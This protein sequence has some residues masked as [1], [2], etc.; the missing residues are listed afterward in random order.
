M[1]RPRGTAKAPKVQEMSYKVPEELQ[2][3]QK[4]P[5]VPCKRPRGTAKV[6]KVLCESTKRATDVTRIPE[7][8]AE[9]TKSYQRLHRKQ[10]PCKVLEVACKFP[11]VL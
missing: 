7:I 1:Q 9:S 6:P 2:K 10:I 8:P 11:D 4:V 5:E 3:Y